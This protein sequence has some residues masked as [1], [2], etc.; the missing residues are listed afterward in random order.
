[1]SKQ[2]KTLILSVIIHCLVQNSTDFAWL[3][4]SYPALWNSTIRESV[5]TI[6]FQ[7]KTPQC[8]IMYL[9]SSSSLKFH[10]LCVIMYLLS[11]SSSKLHIWSD[12]YYSP[13]S[14]LHSVHV[15]IHLLSSSSSKL[16]AVCVWSCIYYL[17]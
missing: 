3:Y 2:L 15:V 5:T 4:I 11:N 1:M 7:F 12:I 10:D 8:M 17:F 9:V 6:Q 14:K 16:H 13:S